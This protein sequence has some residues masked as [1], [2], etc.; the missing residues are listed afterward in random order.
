MATKFSPDRPN[1]NPNFQGAVNL[2]TVDQWYD[3]KAF[4]LPTAGTWETWAAEC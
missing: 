1:W 3:P 2:R 4:S